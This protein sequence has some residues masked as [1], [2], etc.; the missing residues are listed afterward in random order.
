MTGVG[1][2]RRRLGLTAV[3]ALA[4][5]AAS[6]STAAAQPDCAPGTNIE[7]IIDDSL[8]MEDN[9][10]QRYR[11]QMMKII[12]NKPANSKKTLGAVEFSGTA[13][14]I[15]SPQ[16]VQGNRGLMESGI[17]AKVTNGDAGT[18]YN[19]A[20]ARAR[21]DNPNANAR[22]FL[23]DGEHLESEYGPYGNG[24]RGGPKT[25]VV[26]FGAVNP[27]IL[28]QIA[29]ETGGRYYQVG[30]NSELQPVASD[31]SARVNCAPAPKTLVNVF[32]RS[33]QKKTRRVKIGKGVKYVDLD[34]SYLDRFASFNLG[35]FRIQRGKKVVANGKGFVKIKKKKRKG[36]KRRKK[37]RKV[38]KL[39]VTKLEGETFET[40]RLSR[41]RRGTLKFDIRARSGVSTTGVEVQTQVTLGR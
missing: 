40:V 39:K 33:G 8:S 41:L 17:D 25:Y 23:S 13:D 22:I 10:P 35:N 18:N 3:L 5:A 16:L 12:I 4:V 31:I 37:R 7:A 26:G 24:H 2:L 36:G 30:D 34:L 32:R 29:S 21:Q 27:T 9:D 20:F 38:K 6:G 11:N 1:A 28:Q 15:F 14:T 19:A